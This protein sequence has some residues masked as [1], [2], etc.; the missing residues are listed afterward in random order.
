MIAVFIKEVIIFHVSNVLFS[1][2]IAI[3]VTYGASWPCYLRHDLMTAAC[4]T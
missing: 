2:A 4:Y 3:I 1:K